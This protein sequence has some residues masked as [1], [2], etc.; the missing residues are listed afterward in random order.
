MVGVMFDQQERT[1]QVVLTPHQACW[2][3]HCL[4]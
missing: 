2:Q 3:T 4:E 1:R